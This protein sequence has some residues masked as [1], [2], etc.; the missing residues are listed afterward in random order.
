ML[1]VML[2]K[3]LVR[4]DDSIRPQTFFATVTRRRAQKNPV[5]KLVMKVFD[6]SATSLA[7]QA[8]S[9]SRPTQ[10]D[11]REIRQL[12]DELEGRS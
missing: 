4:R 6:G 10:E 5:S 2:E 12:L 7:M 8:L 11:L 1:S 3:G 9:G